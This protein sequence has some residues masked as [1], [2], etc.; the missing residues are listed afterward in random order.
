MGK[1][2]K[3]GMERSVMTDIVDSLLSGESLIAV[4]GY[5]VCILESRLAVDDASIRE[6]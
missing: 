5:L 6:E 2:T 3:A 4:P 1:Q